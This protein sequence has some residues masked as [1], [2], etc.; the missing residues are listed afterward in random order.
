MPRF[1]ITS[2]I[3][4][5]ALHVGAQLAE[6]RPVESVAVPGGLLAAAEIVDCD[7]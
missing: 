2:L 7:P 3:I 5:F 4:I 1:A 6:R